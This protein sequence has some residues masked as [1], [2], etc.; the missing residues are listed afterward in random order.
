LPVSFPPASG[1]QGMM[2]S[3]VGPRHRDQL[4]LD[5]PVQEVVG[6]LLAHEAVQPQLLGR[7]QRLDH[8]PRGVRARADVAHLALADQVVE[9][10]QRLVDRD[11]ALRAVDLVQVDVVGLQAAEAVLTGLHDVEA[12][13]PPGVGVGVVHLAVDL[14]RQKHPV[15]LAALLERHAGHRF[16]LAAPVHVRGVDEVAAGVEEPVDHPARL[17]LL[18]LPPEGHHAQAPDAHLRPGAPQRSVFH[19]FSSLISRLIS[20]NQR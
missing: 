14:G 18:G 3:P 6:R 12:G 17:V 15:P 11:A 20:R 10:A 5:A 4:A 7:P 19:A 13:V 16:R 9:R 2:P 1:D 8:L